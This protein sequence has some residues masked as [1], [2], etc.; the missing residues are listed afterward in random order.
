MHPIIKLFFQCYL[1]WVHMGHPETKTFINRYG[2]CGNLSRFCDRL[3]I[4]N[5]ERNDLQ[6]QLV[7]MFKREHLHSDFPFNGGSQKDFQQEMYGGCG[8]E[9]IIRLSWVESQLGGFRPIPLMNN[10][11]GWL[12]SY[13]SPYEISNIRWEDIQRLWVD[14]GSSNRTTF[15]RSDFE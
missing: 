14:D 10:F 4:S 2:L 5:Y 11:I 1:Q 6:R 15:R 8:H 7:F 12:S 9:N 3:G 13:R